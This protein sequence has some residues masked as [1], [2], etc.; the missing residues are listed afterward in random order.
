MPTSNGPKKLKFDQ[1]ERITN[2]LRDLVRNYPKGLGLVKEFLQ[3]A[4]DAGA[5]RLLMI[6]DRRQH[7]GA[8]SDFPHMDVALGP[9]LLFINDQIF[10]EDDFQRIQQI[11]EGGKVREAAR[12]GRFGQG[13]NTCYSVSDYP[14]LMTGDRVAWFDPHHRVFGGGANANAWQLAEVE[15]FW[16]DWLK[17]F[18]PAGWSAGL[19]TF[20][21]TAFRLPLR[22]E[23]NADQSEI[24]KEPFKEEDFLGILDGLYK[25]GAALLIFLRSV[26]D[27]EVREID[28]DG[29]D[30]L[31]FKITTENVSIVES[32]RSAMRSV[33]AGSPK[34]LL[35]GWIE[36]NSKLPVAGYDH[37][38]S[39]Q[40]SGCSERDELWSVVTGLFRGPDDLLL[41]AALEV[42]SHEEK[43]I[44]WAGA[45]VCRNPVEKDLKQGGLACFLPLPEQTKWPVWLHGW[46]DLSSNRKGITRDADVGEI[47]KSRQSWNK[48]LMEHAVAKAWAILIKNIQGLPEQSLKPYELWLRPPDKTDDVDSALVSGFYNSVAELSVIRGRDYKRDS[49]YHLDEIRDLPAEWNERLSAPLLAEGWVLSHPSLPDFIK[50]EF[51]KVGKFKS[52]ISPKDL[53]AELKQ[54]EGIPDV[55]CS[56]KDAPRPM[57][58][59]RQWIYLLAEFCAGETFDNLQQLPLAILSD[60]LLHTYTKCGK[61]FLAEE[62]ERL[63]LKPQP[64][65]FLE[66]HYQSVLALNHPTDKINLVAFDL[67]GLLEYVPGLLSQSA[68]EHSWLVRFFDYLTSCDL[69][70]IASQKDKLKELPLL[71]DQNSKYIQMGLVN[72]PLVPGKESKE[73]L[74]ALTELGVPILTVS[75]EL[76][77]AISRFS[78]KHTGFVWELTPNDIADN[79]KAH[80]ER[81]SL[82]EEALDNKK[83]LELILDFLS[84]SSWLV[85]DDKRLPFLQQIRLLPTSCGQRITAQNENLY[86]PSFRPPKGFEGKYILLDTGHRDKWLN[87]FVALKVPK[88]DAVRF[89][90]RVLLPAFHNGTLMQCQDYLKWIR[91]DFRLV[92]AHIT[93]EERNELRQEIRQK[94]ILP[95]ESGELKAPC[96]VYRPG[97][98]L[99]LELLGDIAQFPDKTFFSNDKD[100]W[101]KFFDEYELPR[102]PLARDLYLSI[103][104]LSEVANV[105]GTSQIKGKIRRLI[106]HVSEKWSYLS[107]RKVEG[108]LTFTDALSKIPWLPASVEVSNYAAC[109]KWPD[110]LWRAKE[111]VPGRLANLC[112]SKYPILEG[113]EFPKDMSDALGLITTLNLEEVLQHFLKVCALIPDDKNNDAVHKAAE[114][115]YRHI[116]QLEAKNDLS[117]GILDDLREQLCIYINGVWWH[118]SQI[119]FDKL[120]FATEWVASLTTSNL[121]ISDYSIRK[122]LAFLG[123]RQRPDNDDWVLLLTD[124]ADQF[125]GKPLPTAEL[126]DVHHAIRL[127]K[128]ATTEWL[129]DQ[130]VYIPLQDGRLELAGRTLVPDDPRLR[131]CTGTNSLP[132]IEDNE[133]AFDVGRRSGAKSLRGALIE[134]LKYLPAPTRNSAYSLFAAKLESKLRSKQFYQCLQRIAYEEAIRS[135][136]TDLN[137]LESAFSD[138]LTLPQKI[139]IILSPS[140]NVETVVEIDEEEVVVFDLESQSFL[141]KETLR[142][143]LKEGKQRRIKDDIVRAICDLCGLSDQLRLN[144]VLEVEPENMSLVL[145]EEEMSTLPEGQT[146]DL[147]NTYESECIE[148][149]DCSEN[150]DDGQEPDNDVSFDDEESDIYSSIHAHL[151]HGAMSTPNQARGTSAS[152]VTQ[153]SYAETENLP[154]STSIEP[155]TKTGHGSSSPWRDKSSGTGDAR[156]RPD[157]SEASN[158]SRPNHPTSSTNTMTSSSGQAPPSKPY[159]VISK[160]FTNSVKGNQDP[161][162]QVRMRTYVHEKPQDDYDTGDS[163][164]HAKKLGDIGEQIVMEYEK[165]RKRTAEQMPN[166]HEGYDIQSK[167]RDGTRYIEVKSIDGPW[168]IRGVGVS[169]AQYEAAMRLGKEWWL[170]VVEYVTEQPPRTKVHPIANPFHLATE[171][172]FDSGWMGAEVN[173]LGVSP[174]STKPKIG[175]KY[176]REPGEFVTIETTTQRGEFWRVTFTG[177]DGTMQRAMWDASW[178]KI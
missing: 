45:A 138:E 47:T 137:P 178:R 10:S 43:A 80:T 168:G 35:K 166:N 120:P 36:T 49:W 51:R 22:T 124:Y 6:Y 163:D 17:T 1:T 118:P 60:G 136:D 107:S 119:F 128:S 38:F 33:V 171:F 153:P 48:S 129:Q 145:D 151:E 133:D 160:P 14:S 86:I 16:P 89:V 73:L 25:V 75:D 114:G 174:V 170:Y 76:R 116:G 111:L 94:P 101:A 91:D 88:L 98:A 70:T 172:R 110:K 125:K 146:L 159:P 105:S 46:F 106:D 39:V 18:E 4:D 165:K 55:K 52:S 96:L 167:G 103:K 134:R 104:A 109:A 177:S 117:L 141:D 95:V 2:R 152:K 56:I 92:V 68:P 64:E 59:R 144:R 29:V 113:S 93:E 78:S 31:R 54:K 157:D 112:A 162:R 42:S 69:E 7:N 108:S 158:A 53:R 164:S 149:L 15:R 12:T 8:F 37:L 11:G 28:I 57:L 19:S 85:E 126:N 122:G 66:S 67:S 130:D 147:Q 9:S 150:V 24:H 156:T 102:L 173:D 140:I 23:S 99:P 131:K 40:H 143:W 84:S 176:E 63:L 34:E 50:H 82:N 127:L 161:S 100:L 62:D 115:F 3:N 132:F 169:R 5:T 139:Q 81:K 87:L 20:P 97:A 27:L 21:S 155:P 154:P 135:R 77:A 41:H 123:V 58:R 71:K 142:F 79:F 121:N 74:T 148:D 30:H 61:L 32:H 72:T 65:R 13:F 175:A 90:K 83:T 44:P 26:L